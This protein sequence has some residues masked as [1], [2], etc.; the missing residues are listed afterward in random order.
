MVEDM[1]EKESIK[2][3]RLQYIKKDQEMGPNVAIKKE[4]IEDKT[5]GRLILMNS[6]QAHD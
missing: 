5:D 3:A 1:W 6:I 2:L 4:E